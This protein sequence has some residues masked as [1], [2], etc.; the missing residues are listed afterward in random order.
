MAILLHALMDCN[1]HDNKKKIVLYGYCRILMDWAIYD[2]SNTIATF[3]FCGA[4][5]IVWLLCC[6]IRWAVSFIIKEIPLRCMNI[7]LHALNWNSQYIRYTIS[8]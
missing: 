7:V 8:L 3:G 1:I 4:S 5:F 2:N 6:I